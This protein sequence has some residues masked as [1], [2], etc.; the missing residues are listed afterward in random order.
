MAATREARL[1]G[2]STELLVFWDWDTNEHKRYFKQY[3]DGVAVNGQLREKI[4]GA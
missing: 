4:V 2:E 3:V 1:R